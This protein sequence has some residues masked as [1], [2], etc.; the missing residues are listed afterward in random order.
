MPPLPRA[1][2]DKH[3]KAFARAGWRVA[4][5][6]GSHYVLSKPGVDFYLSIPYHSGQIVKTELLKGLI[7]D[8][9]LTNDEYIALFQDKKRS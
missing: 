3:L 6:T 9:G 5:V 7:R 2:A 8:A 1:E 4:R